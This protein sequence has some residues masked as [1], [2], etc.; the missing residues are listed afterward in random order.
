MV[1]AEHDGMAVSRPEPELTLFRR[2]ITE[3]AK[4]RG[5]CMPIEE[6]YELIPLL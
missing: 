6:L 2:R 1:V 5:K 4:I 3:I